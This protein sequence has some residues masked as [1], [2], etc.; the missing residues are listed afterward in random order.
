MS[1]AAQG[2]LLY[3]PRSS[4]YYEPAQE[5]RENLRLMRRIDEQYLA[6]PFYGSRRMYSRCS[7]QLKR[8]GIGHAPSVVR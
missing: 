7:P 6:T 5:I 8:R 1:I 4:Y 2:D 3:L